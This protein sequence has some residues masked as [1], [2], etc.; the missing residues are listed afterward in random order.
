MDVMRVIYANG[1][2]EDF[3]GEILGFGRQECNAADALF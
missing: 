2:D 1:H 3:G